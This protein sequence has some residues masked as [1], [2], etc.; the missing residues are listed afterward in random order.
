MRQIL[1]T[2]FLGL[3]HLLVSQ[4]KT[5]SIFLYLL[6]LYKL[7]KLKWSLYLVWCRFLLVV[8]RR[9]IRFFHIFQA[10]AR[11]SCEKFR[12]CGGGKCCI[13]L[14]FFFFFFFLVLLY[15]RILL[16]PGTRKYVWKS[17][18]LER[19]RR[20]MIRSEHV[21]S[22]KAFLSTENSFR[23]TTPAAMGRVRTATLAVVVD[24]LFW[25]IWHIFRPCYK[26]YNNY[27]YERQFRCNYVATSSLT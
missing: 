4:R 12:D 1:P 22:V 26:L 8:G 25:Y 20:I 17:E 9:W 27:I 6:D 19:K 7:E 10:A 18:G 16:T 11:F 5:W 14:F 15:K 2:Q 23:L 3:L 24:A 13:I 21:C